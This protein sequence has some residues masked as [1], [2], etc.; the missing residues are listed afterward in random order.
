MYVQTRR[1]KIAECKMDGEISQLTK[2]HNN[3]KN[4]LHLALFFI[5]HCKYSIHLY[6]SI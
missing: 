5:A 6:K 2:L 3:K 4:K 1:A